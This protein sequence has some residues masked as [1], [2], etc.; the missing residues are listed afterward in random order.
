MMTEEDLLEGEAIEKMASPAP[1]FYS[2]GFLWSQEAESGGHCLIADYVPRQADQE[3]I[4]HARA[5]NPK[6]RAEARRLQEQNTRLS[7]ENERLSELRCA[8]EA[9]VG[10]TLEVI[11]TQAAKRATET[12]ARQCA[13][14]VG[15][16]G[17]L[18]LTILREYDLVGAEEK[19]GMKL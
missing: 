14:L 10:E 7:E 11:E 3:F 6:L 8:T 17:H 18:A 12:T 15:G 13:K 5:E 1:W 9:T 19:G 2:D 4:V 16:E